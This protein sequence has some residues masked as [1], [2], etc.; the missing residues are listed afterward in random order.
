MF[1]LVSRMSKAPLDKD[2]LRQCYPGLWIIWPNHI[3]IIVTVG[4]SFRS[5]CC[6]DL[7][8]KLG[9]TSAVVSSSKD[10]VR[11]Y[12]LWIMMMDSTSLFLSKSL[13]VFG[14]L[15]HCWLDPWTIFG[16]TLMTSSQM[17]QSLDQSRV[18]SDSD[19]SGWWLDQHSA[20]LIWTIWA[21]IIIIGLTFKVV[22]MT[23]FRISSKDSTG[24]TNLVVD[25][26]SSSV[27]DWPTCDLTMSCW[28][29]F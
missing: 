16:S 11:L 10:N 15:W 1:S 26:I 7:K 25:Q 27:D 24:T 13:T 3:I 23:T 28:H 17:I 9:L 8:M 29:D 4:L 14:R 20:A 12:D 6:P 19:P 18:N 22:L 2:W 21:S 5:H